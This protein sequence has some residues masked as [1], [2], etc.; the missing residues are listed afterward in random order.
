VARLEYSVPARGFVVR[1]PVEARFP[2][3]TQTVSEAHYR[4]TMCIGSLYRGLERPKGVIEQPSPPFVQ[5]KERVE[6]Y[7]YSLSV[8]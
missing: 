1:I 4:L 3:P 5:V 6:L 7:L 2:V 8:S